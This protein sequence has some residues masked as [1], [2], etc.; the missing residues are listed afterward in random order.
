M[1]A[2]LSAGNCQYTI[3]STNG[4]TTLNQAQP[5]GAN[6]PP[7]SPAIYYGANLNVLGTAPVL[8]VLDIYVAG[9][10][11][12]TNTIDTGTGTAVGQNFPALNGALGVRLKGNL[13]VVTT[14]TAAGTWLL[15]WD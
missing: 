6:S 2:V 10:A 12:V 1:P 4:T 7:T 9:T 13:V 15:G 5:A 3:I 14:G 11:T 8:A